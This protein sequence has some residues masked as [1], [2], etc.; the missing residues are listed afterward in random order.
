MPTPDIFISYAREDQAV[1]RRFADALQA[2]GFTV[3]WDQALNAG[4]AFDRVTEQALRD[5]RAV[6]VLW[7]PHSVE[8]D[9]VRA[10]AA[11]A[12]E[13][14]KLVPVLI[15]PC[16]VPIKF[17]LTQTADLSAWKGATQDAAWRQFVAGLKQ[18]V[19]GQGAQQP[20]AS[21]PSDRS[22][23]PRRLAFLLSIA[24][25]AL[26]VVAVGAWFL[27]RGAGN[28]AGETAEAQKVSI[29]VLPFANL[30]GDPQQEYFSDGL[31][32]EILNELAQN[33]ALEVTGRTSSF[34]YKGQNQDLRK[35][36]GELNVANLLEGSIRRDG[37]SL[38]VTAQLIKGASG[39]HLWSRTYDRQ[40]SD[41]FAVQSELAADVAQALSVKLQVNDISRAKGGTTNVEAYDLWLHARELVLK[42]ALLAS[43]EEPIALTREAVRLD[44][45]FS[46]A[47]SQLY[48]ELTG[49]LRS[50]TLEQTPVVRQE[51]QAAARK[52]LELTPDSWWGRL[53]EGVL[54]AARHEWG[55]AEAAIEASLV[56]APT[57]ASNFTRHIQVARFLTAVGRFNDS[58]EQD[59]ITR[60]YQSDML[61]ASLPVQSKLQ[62]LGRPG[63]VEQEYQRSLSMAGNHADE[64]FLRLLR[65]LAEE[66]PDMQAIDAQLQLVR[67]NGSR[68]TQSFEPIWKVIAD[69]PAARA[70]LLELMQSPKMQGSYGMGFI[71]Q[72]A[73]ALGDKDLALTALEWATLQNNILDP[74]WL[75]PYSG[76]RS[77]LRFKQIVKQL[78]IDAYWRES[79]KWG[80]FCKP[81]GD[82]DFE[83][84]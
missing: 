59:R 8:S 54:L 69:R 27:M 36:A 70:A 32:E 16:S 22:A 81:V 84:Q 62:A 9:W 1:A 29:A 10:E 60:S 43:P 61:A 80:D 31:T 44:P 46:L 41:V 35:I 5:S 74:L 49:A 3:W 50:L 78:K 77:D 52:V 66:H 25:V 2:E 38:R 26:L 4:Q 83:C 13:Q 48:N 45:G 30:S 68:W 71:A 28:A 14:H 33:E 11:E 20:A 57:N 64:H 67:E 12:D 24:A 73:D 6:V 34:A 75:L 23:P 15:D 40:L 7:S 42:G 17:K 51:Y 76:V 82:D 53:M 58:L 21:A 55:Q 56:A 79:G 72:L 37:Q 65:L 63:E 47:W 19:G 39:A 18:H